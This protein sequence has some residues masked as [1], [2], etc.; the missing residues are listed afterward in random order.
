MQA[1]VMQPNVEQF[2]DQVPAKGRREDARQLAQLMHEITGETATLWEP[3]MIGYGQYHYKY[4]SGHEGDSFLSGFSPRKAN[5]VIYIM[6]GF[7]QFTSLLDRLGKHKTG[8]S[9]LY[10]GRLSNVDMD[11]LQELVSSAH[12]HMVEK[13]KS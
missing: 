4:E 6:P 11:V 13:Y 12:Q 10:L 3:T 9:C 2:I 5:M 7:S 1:T 8:A